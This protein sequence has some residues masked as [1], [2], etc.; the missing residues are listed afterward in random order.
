ME[1]TNTKAETPSSETK[2]TAQEGSEWNKTQ[3]Q[4]AENQKEEE[5][6]KIPN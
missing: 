2:D 3:A 1:D 6:P 5:T 4:K